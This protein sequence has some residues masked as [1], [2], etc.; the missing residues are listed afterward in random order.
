MTQTADLCTYHDSRN[1]DCPWRGD[2]PEQ[3]VTLTA[4]QWATVQA[5]L[6]LAAEVLNAEGMPAQIVY[7]TMKAYHTISAQVGYDND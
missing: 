6:K 2:N 5:S 7:D 3:T 4:D 1:C